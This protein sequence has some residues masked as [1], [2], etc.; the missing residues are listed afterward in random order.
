MKPDISIIIVSYNTADLPRKCLQSIDKQQGIAAE[1]FVVDN[2][3]QD[4]SAQMVENEFLQVRLIANAENF[5]F[6]KANNIAAREAKGRYLYLLNPDTE[7]PE[8][9]CLATII[10]YMNNHLEVGMAGNKIYFPNLVPQ[11]SVVHH[12]PGQRYTENEL[13]GLSGNI[14]WLL[15]ACLMIRRE[16]YE[17]VGGF[18]EIFFLY[19]EDLDLGLEI[20]KAG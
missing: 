6:G 19:G 20:R 2:N 10:Y 13:N 8:Q 17:K 18:D 14:A 7:I 9:N 15:G 12:Y 5:G 1:I 11:E 3:S 4:Q 16:V